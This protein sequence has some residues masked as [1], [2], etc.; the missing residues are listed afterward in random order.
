[1]YETVPSISVSPCFKLNDEVF[2]VKGSIASLNVAVTTLSRFT[3]TALFT[4]E[5]EITEGAVK[6]PV[7]KFHS[8]LLTIAIPDAFLAS[9]VIFAV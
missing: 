1:M 9:F 7:V 4:G 3:S 6:L 8:K 5:V 2:I